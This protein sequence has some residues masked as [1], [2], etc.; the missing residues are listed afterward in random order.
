[1]TKDHLDELLYNAR[2][3]CLR[4]IE[5]EVVHQRAEIQ[6][7]HFYPKPNHVIILSKYGQQIVSNAFDMS[8]LMNRT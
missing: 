2:R 6:F 3:S 1:M 5:D 8:N 7:L 4:M